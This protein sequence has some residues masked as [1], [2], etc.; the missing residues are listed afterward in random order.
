MDKVLGMSLMGHEPAAQYRG[1]YNR[2]EG[3][4]D[5]AEKVDSKD[6]IKSLLKG[7]QKGRVIMSATPAS[8][9]LFIHSA[10]PVTLHNLSHTSKG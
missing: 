10:P 5:D 9:V 2:T 8:G 1:V 7:E 6:R 4:I 3:L